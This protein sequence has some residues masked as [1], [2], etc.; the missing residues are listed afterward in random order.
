MLVLTLSFKW[1]FLFHSQVV[2]PISSGFY[3]EASNA[4]HL[5]DSISIT[6]MFCHH[7]LWYVKGYQPPHFKIIS[8][9]L[10]SVPFLRISPPPP[11]PPAPIPLIHKSVI[12]SFP[13]F[14]NNRNATVKFNFN[15]YYPCKTK[16]G[17]FHIRN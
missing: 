14:L 6:G 2:F 9:L 3:G 7:E 12:P 13:I 1:H 10:G 8:P 16:T 15:K 4:L 17:T 11:P 5:I